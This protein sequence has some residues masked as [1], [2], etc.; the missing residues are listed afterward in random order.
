MIFACCFRAEY[1]LEL[2]RKEDRKGELDEKVIENY[3]SKKTIRM[4]PAGVTVRE[5]KPM[6]LPPTKAEIEQKNF[7]ESKAM[8]REL[9]NDK[10]AYLSQLMAVWLF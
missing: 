4:Y 8:K 2:Q 6:E 10:N 7:A 5:D 9:R 3:R 1:V